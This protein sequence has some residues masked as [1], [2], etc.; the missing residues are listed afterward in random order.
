MKCGVLELVIDSLY[1]GKEIGNGLY[2]SGCVSSK[3][4]ISVV[5]PLPSQPSI[6]IRIISTPFKFPEKWCGWYVYYTTHKN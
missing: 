4:L 5:F 3:F 6:A 2:K 1:V